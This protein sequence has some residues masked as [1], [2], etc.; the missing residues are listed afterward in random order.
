[1]MLQVAPQET[2]Q[3]HPGNNKCNSLVYL[4]QHDFSL[5]RPVSC[6]RMRRAG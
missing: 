5:L 2:E 1:M 6:M 4:T 3:M